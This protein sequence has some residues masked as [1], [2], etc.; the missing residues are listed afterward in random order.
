MKPKSQFLLSAVLLFSVNSCSTLT[1]DDLGDKNSIQENENN[2][3]MNFVKKNREGNI[4]WEIGA[5]EGN[6]YQILNNISALFC[7]VKVIYN[8]GD[9]E[10][11]NLNPGESSGVLPIHQEN[12][13]ID[14]TS[15]CLN[16]PSVYRAE[17]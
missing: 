15:K 3:P 16:Q 5:K 4:D 17:M 13:G 12:Y 7:K 14:L 6:G 9:V 2:I 10:I 8:D 1:T 11:F